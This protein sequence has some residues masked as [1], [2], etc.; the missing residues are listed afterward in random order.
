M[1]GPRGGQERRAPAMVGLEG[2]QGVGQVGQAEEAADHVQDHLGGGEARPQA[3]QDRCPGLR[4]GAPKAFGVRAAA[5]GERDVG[6]R[7]APDER[8]AVAGPGDQGHVWAIERTGIPGC[9]QLVLV[10]GEIVRAVPMADAGARCRVPQ[11]CQRDERP[12]PGQHLLG[13]RDPPSGGPAVLRRS[14]QVRGGQLQRLRAAEPDEHH[15]GVCQ[16]PDQEA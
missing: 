16:S 12:E 4:G 9:L 5:V 15:L 7:H 10:R 6:L 13:L 14:G 11:G 2:C 3:P 8:P 1:R